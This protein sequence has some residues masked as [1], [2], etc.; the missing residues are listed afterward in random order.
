VTGC[1]PQL[2]AERA[3]EPPKVFTKINLHFVVTGRGF[4]AHKVER[5]VHLS[6][7]K[8]CSASIMLGK[9]GVEITQCRAA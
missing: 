6:A 4:S 7:D 8:Y 2:Q 9:G 1:A 5:A 3:D